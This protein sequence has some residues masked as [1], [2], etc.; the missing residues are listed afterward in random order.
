M[1]LYVLF[2]RLFILMRPLRVK[3]EL[4]LDWTEASKFSFVENINVLK[5][6]FVKITTEI[7]NKIKFYKI[8]FLRKAIFRKI[9]SEFWAFCFKFCLLIGYGVCLISW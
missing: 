3:Q 6:G 5:T 1:T 9:F 4:L 2:I 8:G 7:D